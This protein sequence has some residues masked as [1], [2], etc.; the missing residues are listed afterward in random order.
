MNIV[1]L[2]MAGTYANGLGLDAIAAKKRACSCLQYA[3]GCRS[4]V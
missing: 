1:S 3:D 4:F 2:E